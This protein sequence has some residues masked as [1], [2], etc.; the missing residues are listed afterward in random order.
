MAAI[1]KICEF[2]GNYTG[3]DMYSYKRNHIQVEPQYR[4]NFRGKKAILTIKED[5][6]ILRGQFSSKKYDVYYRYGYDWESERDFRN[7]RWANVPE[8]KATFEEW[9][10]YHFKEKPIMTYEYCLE[11]V[12]ENWSCPTNRRKFYETTFDNPKKVIKRIK[13]LVGANN[14]T[15][16]MPDGKIIDPFHLHLVF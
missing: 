8:D 10:Y 4:K 14:L 2:S 6:L 1:E 15:I 13:R 12:D 11:I 9:L 16:V 7:S 5:G 3:P